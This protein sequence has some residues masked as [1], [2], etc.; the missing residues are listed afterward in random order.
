MYKAGIPPIPQQFC[1]HFQQ[2]AYVS[3]RK[4]GSG[5]GRVYGSDQIAERNRNNF[6]FFNSGNC[7][8]TEISV[9]TFQFYESPYKYGRTFTHA[10]T[11]YIL[12]SSCQPNRVSDWLQRHLSPHHLEHVISLLQALPT[13]TIQPS[14]VMWCGFGFA[15]ADP[16]HNTPL[17]QPPY[18]QATSCGA[19]LVLHMQ[20]HTTTHLS[21]SRHTTKQ[22]HVVRLWFCTCRST[23][24]T[25]STATLQP[26]NV[27]W[28]GFGF[29]HADPHH[30][31]L[32]QPPYNQATSC[33]AA[34]V[35]HMQI[36]TT[37]L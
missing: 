24:Q 1:H 22:R 14:N 10:H 5:S 12:K 8:N 11:H 33:G 31:P 7:Q 21:H 4:H 20:I 18:N 36:H 30:R 34:L 16:H 26:S 28:C 37:D 27:M 32:A 15:H 19:A 29:A 6:F 3:F 2:C 25:S 13:A 9:C 35:L 23:P 17:T